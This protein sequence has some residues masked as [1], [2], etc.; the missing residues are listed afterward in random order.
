MTYAIDPD[1]NPHASDYSSWFLWPTFSF[2]VYPG[3]ILNTYHWHALD[4][5][6]TLA[7][8]GWYSVDGAPSPII[9]ELA[10]QDRDT[11]LAED[12]CLVESV[13]RGLNSIGYH[14]GPLVLDPDFG[15]NS[16]HSIKCLNDWREE[17]LSG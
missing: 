16:E 4:V 8:R 6:R 11:T 14:P 15:V 2:Q 9:E 7:V 5:E 17:L 3:N 10:E 13:Q 12:V 1:T